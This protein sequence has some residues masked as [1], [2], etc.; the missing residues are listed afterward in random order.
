MNIKISENLHGGKGSVL[1]RHI[2]GSEVLHDKCKLYAEVVL[3]PGCSIGYH[4]HHGECEIYYILSGE[5]SYND[6][7]SER[8]VCAGDVTLTPDG[9]GHG[10]ENN[11]ENELRFMALIVND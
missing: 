6:N 10:I 7:G 8:R 2:A 1:L 3:A 5:G 4:T 9:F 11:G